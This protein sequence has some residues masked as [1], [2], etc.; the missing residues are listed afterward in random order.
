MPNC[1]VAGCARKYYAKGWCEMHYQRVVKH[2][3]P[4]GGPTTHAA[5]EDRFWRGVEKAGPSDCW[6]YVR[7]QNRG[8]Y[9]RFQS[10]GKGS[11]HVGAHRYSYEMHHGPIPEGMFV[12]HSCDN[13]RC[14]NPAHLSVGTP[15]DNTADMIRKGRARPVAPKGVNSPNA[16]LND[17]AV[18]II[19][20]N[21]EISDRELARRFGVATRTVHR[22]R[23][24]EGWLHVK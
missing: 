14:V 18:R 4:E 12:L 23:V 2:G 6:L 5:P 1:S 7:G 3:T 17:E 19:R 9:G 21:P 10:G 13:P 8:P 16:R 11:P 22:V 24:G 20:A 15:K